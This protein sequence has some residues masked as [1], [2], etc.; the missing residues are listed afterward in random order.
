VEQEIAIHVVGQDRPAILYS[1]IVLF[2]PKM[3]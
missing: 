3:G 2:Q 1:M